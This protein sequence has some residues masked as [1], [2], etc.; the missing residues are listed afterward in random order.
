MCSGISGSMLKLFVI[1]YTAY[2]MAT[3]RYIEENQ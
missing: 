1:R 2:D 3:V